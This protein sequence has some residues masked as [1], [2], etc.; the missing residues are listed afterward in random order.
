MRQQTLLLIILIA[1]CCMPMTVK[2][3]T[4]VLHRAFFFSLNGNSYQLMND[5]DDLKFENCYA[6]N[7]KN[8]QVGSVAG[9]GTVTT[10]KPLGLNGNTSVV[11]HVI[12][13]QEKATICVSAIDGEKEKEIKE[14][15]LLKGEVV[16]ESILVKDCNS[17][18]K[19]CIKGKE[20]KFDLVS[21][22]IIRNENGYLHESFNNMVADNHEAFLTNSSERIAPITK[23][24]NYTGTSLSN[25][26]QSEGCILFLDFGTNSFRTP[27]IAITNGNMVLMSFKLAKGSGSGV[28]A[29]FELTCNGKAQMSVINSERLNELSNTQSL[30]S[31]SAPKSKEWTLYKV[32]VTNMSNTTQFTFKAENLYLDD[33]RLAPYTIIDETSDNSTTI[34]NNEGLCTVALNRTLGAGYWNTLCLPFD[35]TQDSFV[36]ETDTSAEIR[37]LRSVSDNDGVFHF[38]KVASDAIIEAGTPFIVKV[39]KKLEN[40]KFVNV[41]VK[42]D[43]I[44]EVSFDGTSDYKFIGTYSP[45][46][47]TT[48]KTNLFLGTDEKLH[49]PSTE[50]TNIMKGLRAYFVVPSGTVSSRVNINGEEMD[51]I[52]NIDVESNTDAAV[53]DLHGQRHH[54]G[55]LHNGIYICN[56]RKVIVK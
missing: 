44:K 20:G 52:G 26:I 51:A 54:A 47:L 46:T 21:F 33:I 32:L 9:I 39:E 27:P 17:T 1:C 38:D 36:K 3:Q 11:L 15:S 13:S 5:D 12:A 8:L 29:K 43:P 42:N 41:V 40:P 16:L 34:A 48:S 53:Y 49:Y 31:G 7:G 2:G 28:V 45:I 22:D 4:N 6:I 14:Y 37:T 23:C 10:N 19:I 50:S 35:I 25:V 55:A 24:D 18:T 56:G 30:P